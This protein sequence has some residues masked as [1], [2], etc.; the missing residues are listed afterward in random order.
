MN[1]NVTVDQE[2]KSLCHARKFCLRADALHDTRCS[3]L[4]LR[5]FVIA[6]R[7]PSIV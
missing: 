4:L 5:N 7:Y 6:E 2:T 3:L 1:I